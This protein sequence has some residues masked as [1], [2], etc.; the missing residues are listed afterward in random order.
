MYIGI[1]FDGVCVRN[2]KSAIKQDVIG[3]AHVLRVLLKAGNKLILY[4][5]RSGLDLGPA[6]NWFENKK[7]ELFG[8]NHNP[9][10]KNYD[11]TSKVF[12]HLYIDAAG[13]GIPLIHEGTKPYVNWSK[14]TSMLSDRDILTKHEATEIEKLIAKELEEERRKTKATFL[15]IDII[16]NLAYYEGFSVDDTDYALYF[17]NKTDETHFVRMEDDGFIEIFRVD[18]NLKIFKTEQ[19]SCKE[20]GYLNHICL[21]E[22][23]LTGHPGKNVQ[24]IFFYHN[25]DGVKQYRILG[26]YNA[27]DVYLDAELDLG[28]LIVTGTVIL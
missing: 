24:R 3:A 10:Q 25:I 5:T 4:T 28:R 22:E 6:I 11:N 7:I 12:C 18:S 26:D 20:I 21:T 1:E 23:H 27:P 8:V 19:G 2:E 13:L 17:N 14:V 9:E 15:P 16:D